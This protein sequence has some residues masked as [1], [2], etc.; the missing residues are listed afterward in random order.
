MKPDLIMRTLLSS[1]EVLAAPA[2]RQIGHLA[3]LRLGTMVDELALEF[4]D[5]YVVAAP[6]MDEL[7]WSG[8]VESALALLDAQLRSMSGQAHA[9][10]WTTDALVFAPE[11]SKVRELAAIALEAA[12]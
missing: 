5:I 10:L 4:D 2:A 7:G 9:S 8:A 12:R 11:W 6:I 1:V 3:P